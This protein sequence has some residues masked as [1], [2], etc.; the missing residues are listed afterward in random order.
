MPDGVRPPLSQPT[1]GVGIIG[2]GSIGRTHALAIDACEGAVVRAVSSRSG[3]I[4][5]PG[6]AAH[7]DY[8]ELLERPDIDVV[9]ICSP[10]GD[11]HRHAS[12]ALR[13][14]KHVVVEKPIAL[15]MRDADELV[16]LARSEKLLLASIAQRRLEPLNAAIKQLMS[17][18]ALGKPVLGEALVR[19]HRTQEYYDAA[20]WRGTLSADGGV[21]LNQA[22]QT[23]DLLCWWLGPTADEMGVAATLTH[24]IEAEDTAAGVFR[25][26]NG[27]IGVVSATTSAWPGSPELLNLF[28][29]RG[30]FSLSSNEIVAWSFP[31]VPR[32]EIV[33]AAAGS[34]AADPSGIGFSGHRAQWQDILRALRDG[35]ETAISGADALDTL[36]LILGLR[37]SAG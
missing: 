34:G 11:H 32:P 29:D 24:D 37:R 28:F 16:Q 36:R 2:Y 25:F 4:P 3:N 22:L 27:A 5:P 8:R 19:W 21:L 18:G 31:D 17:D 7:Q 12:D 15:T 13:A 23:I 33:G 26:A 6:A 14:G 30:Q 20:P 10:S 9:A 1:L 35:T